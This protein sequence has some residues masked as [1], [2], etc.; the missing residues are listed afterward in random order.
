MNDFLP[1]AY[2]ILGDV[3][4][5]KKQPEQALAEREKDVA[6]DPNNADALVGLGEVLIYIGKIEDSIALLKKAIRFNP[7][8]DVWYFWELGLFFFKNQFEHMNNFA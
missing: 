8:H 7:N 2:R 3:F 4:L 1:K 6:L 5:Y